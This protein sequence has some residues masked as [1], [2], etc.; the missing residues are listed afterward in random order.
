[1]SYGFIAGAG[2]TAPYKIIYGTRPTTAA[3][4]TLWVNTQSTE[5]IWIDTGEPAE[6]ATGD[7]WV[8]LGAVARTEISL[9]NG[10]TETRLGI[11]R[12]WIYAD[13]GWQKAYAELMS[14]GSWTPVIIDLFDNGEEC[15]DITGGWTT[16]NDKGFVDTDLGALK[17]T[18]TG[19][20]IGTARA[21]SIAGFKRLTVRGFQSNG[22]SNVSSILIC[23]GDVPSTSAIKAQLD[24]NR[25]TTGEELSLDLDRTVLTDDEYYI[26][27][28]TNV[29]LSGGKVETVKEIFL[30]G[31]Q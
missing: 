29:A 23:S 17:L 28:K 14:G 8:E 7:I 1:M 3:K 16:K 10:K 26:F 15:S 19:G 11:H 5:H 20:Y 9:T 31:R 21:I 30:E 2:G 12:V 22:T 4:N 25:N 27:F 6:T 18:A 24:F 13:A